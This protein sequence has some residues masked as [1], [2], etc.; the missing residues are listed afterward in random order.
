M[1]ANALSFSA[2]ADRA[3]LMGGSSGGNLA[4]AT[5]LSII[6]EGEPK[7]RGL[8]VACATT[9]YPSEIPEEYKSFWHPEQTLDAAM[10][11]R[12]AMMPCMGM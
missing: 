11:N 6:D 4:C 7:P 1:R 2:S 12:A 5:T 10:L 9:I 8:I 3:V